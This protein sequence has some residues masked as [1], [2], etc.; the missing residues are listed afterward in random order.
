MKKTATWCSTSMCEL[1]CSTRIHVS[2][3]YF[4]IALRMSI[5]RD[6]LIY[7]CPHKRTLLAPYTVLTSSSPTPI[8]GFAFSGSHLS[9]IILSISS[10]G[11][12]SYSTSVRALAA[13]SL[14]KHS[15]IA[16]ARGNA[17]VSHAHLP[18]QPKRVCQ[19]GLAACPLVKH[20]LMETAWL[21]MHESRV[22]FFWSNAYV[23]SRLESMLV[24]KHS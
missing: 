14:V 4:Y 1:H 3:S 18:F 24:E 23:G 12:S 6:E 10:A 2:R 22:C 21:K 17:R 5:R 13:C 11:T 7:T 20:S 15:L 16:P 8:F 9:E 19:L